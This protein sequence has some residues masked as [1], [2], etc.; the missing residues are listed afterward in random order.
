MVAA[1]A[2]VVEVEPTQ[3]ALSQ[4]TLSSLFPITSLSKY[5][6]RYW[7]T[8]DVYNTPVST[9]VDT[10]ATIVF[11]NTVRAERSE[12]RHRMTPIAVLSDRL[13]VGGATGN[14]V[15]RGPVRK[16][17]TA[18][19]RAGMDPTL[20]PRPATPPQQPSLY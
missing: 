13:W 2:A 12:D 15:L 4:D 9:T 19:Q 20:S 5:Y 11:S 10:V 18:V 16:S 17:S 14:R 7:T 3:P 6:Y 8:S 1:I